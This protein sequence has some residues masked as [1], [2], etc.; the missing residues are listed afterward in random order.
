MV[1]AWDIAWARRRWD[2]SEPGSKHLAAWARELGVSRG[3]LHLAL[4][5]MDREPR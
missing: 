1:T 3:A 5:A 2:L 4:L